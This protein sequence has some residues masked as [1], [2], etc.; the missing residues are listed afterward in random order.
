MKIDSAT[1]RSNM[2]DEI[3]AILSTAAYG[4][5]QNTAQTATY[6]KVPLANPVAPAASGGAIT[7]DVTPTPEDASPSAGTATRLGFYTAKTGGTLIFTCG[8]A[9]SGSPDVTMAD[10]TI[11]TT[12]TVQL[13]SLVVTVPSGTPDVT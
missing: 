8:I 13:T 9:T 1:L 12:D 4:R 6:A 2:A 7:F 3:T 5:F 11:E 10:N